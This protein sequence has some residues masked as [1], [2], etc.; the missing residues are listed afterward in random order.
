M[1]TKATI[2]II[3]SGADS[4]SILAMPRIVG[5]QG[6]EGCSKFFLSLED[7][8]LRI[9]GSSKIRVVLKKLGRFACATFAIVKD[10][11]VIII[12]EFTGRMMEG[13]RYSEGLHQALEAK[14]NLRIQ[15]ENQTLVF[16]RYKLPPKKIT[17]HTLHSPSMV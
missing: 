12:D 9:F 11:K 15:S 17:Q 10:G 2:P 1:L 5:R 4:P 14:E 3:K 13:R 7:D 8:L 16:S 6:D